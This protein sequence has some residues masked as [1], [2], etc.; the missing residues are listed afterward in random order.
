MLKSV[1]CHTKR[2]KNCLLLA[3]SVLFPLSTRKKFLSPYQKNEI[4]AKEIS[5][6][7]VLPEACIEMLMTPAWEFVSEKII[8]P[9][10][11]EDD[12]DEQGDEEELKFF[13][14][15]A[16]CKQRD[17]SGLDSKAAE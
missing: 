8:S 3:L 11:K 4:S 6:F 7:T 10:L 12:K 17:Q 15:I 5:D 13:R 2:D 9:S 14:E 1:S 16:A